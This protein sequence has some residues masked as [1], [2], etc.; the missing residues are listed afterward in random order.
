LILLIAGCSGAMDRSHSGSGWAR[1]SLVLLHPQIP[2]AS[3]FP[4]IVQPASFIQSGIWSV[5]RSGSNRLAAHPW[6]A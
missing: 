1:S 4:W 3:K 5:Q 2:D 6:K